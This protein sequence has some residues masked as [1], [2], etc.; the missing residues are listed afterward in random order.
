MQV[1]TLCN[2]KG[3]T[4]KTTT[5]VNLAHGIALQGKRV[6]LVDLDGQGQATTCLGLDQEPGVF[7]LLIAEKTAAQVIRETGRDNLFII[8]GNK[9]TL[10]AL[11]VIAAEGRAID[12]LQERLK[13]VQYGMIIFDTAPSIN[14]LTGMA[15]YM[16]DYYL[17]P[18]ACDFLSSEGVYK[19]LDL[20]KTEL[21]SKPGYH[22]ELLAVIPTFYD[23]ISKEGKANIEDLKKHFGGKVLDPIH[24]ATILREAP[25]FGKTIFEY[26]K[27]SR[28]AE[29][30]QALVNH[31]LEVMK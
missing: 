7:D 16:S 6:L 1:L 25:A 22:A 27:S 26:S 21:Q 19:I 3:G 9:R 11:K 2:E 29:E 20:I 5:A 31:V 28:A 15:L 14:D 12:Y 23:Q 10:T 8:P 30:Y 13:G 24:R 4:A 17:I 18:S